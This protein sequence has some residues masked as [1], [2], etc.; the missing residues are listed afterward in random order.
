MHNQYYEGVLQLR[1]PTTEVINFI[2]SQCK[3]ENV[4]ITK[5][6][7]EDEGFDYYLTSRK[8]LHKIG[9][10]LQQ[11]FTGQ[12]KVSSRLFSKDRLTSKDIYRVN[13]MFR[14]FPL[15]KGDIFEYRGETLKI[16][17]IG[18]KLL[19]K[20]VKTGIKKWIPFDDLCIS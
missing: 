12:L 19:A 17:N 4:L 7:K 1:N 20:N 14:L 11:S 6:V 5:T 10:K 13:V 3:K 2:K 18:T 9:K 16:I 15:R 8:F